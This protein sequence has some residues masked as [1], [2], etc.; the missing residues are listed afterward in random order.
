M[1]RSKNRENGYARPFVRRRD[2]RAWR[3][4]AR[5]FGSKHGFSLDYPD[6]AISGPAWFCEP[7]IC[8]IDCAFDPLSDGNRNILGVITGKRPPV[9]SRNWIRG[10][11][12]GHAQFSKKCAQR[13]AASAGEFFLPGQ[14]ATM[15]G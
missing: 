2:D 11:F 12:S 6:A 7:P 8:V 3:R 14:R 5:Q 10:D 4:Q 15:P 9:F 1:A 13:G